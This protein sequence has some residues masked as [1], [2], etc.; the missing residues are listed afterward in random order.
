MDQS[1]TFV[2]FTRYY[3]AGFY[4]FV[5]AFYTARILIRQKAEARAM[6]H[7]GGRGSVTWWNHMLFRVFRVSIWLICVLRCFYPSLDDYLGVAATLQTLPVLLMG[8]ILLTMG[9]GFTLVVHFHLGSQWRSGIDP[10]GPERVL[11][12]GVYHYSRHP[13]FV[14]V[15]ISQLGFFLALPSVFTAICLLVGWTTLYRQALAEE[16]HL[17]ERFSDAYRQYQA[18]TPRWL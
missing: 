11:T 8:L 5:A 18:S 2:D 6:V 9:F 7:P 14:G 10:Q 17:Q 12:Q 1:L 3:L 16:Q 13:M 4:T 15:G